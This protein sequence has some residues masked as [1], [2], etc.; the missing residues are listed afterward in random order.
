MQVIIDGTAT[1]VESPFD[2]SAEPVAA[3]EP[4]VIA[5]VVEEKKEEAPVE[6]AV[7]AAPVKEEAPVVQ[8]EPVTETAGKKNNK[9]KKGKG[10]AAAQAPAAETT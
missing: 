1:S 5:P 10:A 7:E 3:V 8:P 6:V 2:G 4:E 9:K